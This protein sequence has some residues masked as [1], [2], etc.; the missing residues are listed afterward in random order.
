M[1]RLTPRRIRG[2]RILRDNE[3]ER[4]VWRRIREAGESRT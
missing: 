1:V 4:K 2:T 3:G